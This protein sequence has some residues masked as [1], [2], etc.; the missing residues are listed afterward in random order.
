MDQL[1]LYGIIA[2]L[3]AAL[4]FFLGHKTKSGGK[5]D[6]GGAVDRYAKRTKK[7][8][9]DLADSLGASSDERVARVLGWLRKR[10]GPGK[11]DDPDQ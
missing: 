8:G 9:L 2:V 7:A 11:S 10:S 3:V 1:G 6:E 4:G 5:P